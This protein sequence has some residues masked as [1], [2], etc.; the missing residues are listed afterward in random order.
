MR[1][2]T[3]SQDM[4]GTPLLRGTLRSAQGDLGALEPLLRAQGHLPPTRVDASSRVD[5]GNINEQPLFANGHI[6]SVEAC[7]VCV[8]E[9]GSDVPRLS[10]AEEQVARV[11]RG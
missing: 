11:R 2:Q 6:V 4:H 1:G 9:R 5:V 3:R 8:L 7:I 10:F